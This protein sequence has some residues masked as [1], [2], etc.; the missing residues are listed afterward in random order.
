MAVT[1]TDTQL[2][3][4][5]LVGLLASMG[6]TDAIAAA[7]QARSDFFTFDKAADDG[8][9]ATATTETYTGIYLPRACLLKAATY[10]ATTGGIT[11]DATNNATI[12]LSKRDSAAANKTTVASATTNVAFGNVTQGAGKAL[13]LSA[14]NV[15]I[16]AGSTVTFEIAK[17]GT[18]VV[19]RA[20]RV[21]LEVEWD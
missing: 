13:T 4:R 3:K 6:L 2:V 1:F 12:T 11:A 9:A 17:G 8:T 19:V 14:A 20:G 5:A 10:L 15:A 7:A 21:T 18:G 16:S